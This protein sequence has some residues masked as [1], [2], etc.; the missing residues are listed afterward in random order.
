MPGARLIIN[1]RYFHIARAGEKADGKHSMTKEAAMGLVEYVGTREGVELNVP[2]QMSLYGK[3]G[4]P[5]NLDPLRLSP[6]VAARPA[7]QKQINTIIDLLEAI[8]EAKNTLEF[9]DY[10]EH[11]TIGNATELISH[12]SELGLGYA[13][14]YGKAANLVEYVG[15]RPGVV[16]VG[17][18]GLFSSSPNVDMKK[19]QEEI[20]N[21]KGNIWTHVISLRREDADM[22][23]YN[24]QKPWRDLVMQKIDVI[25]KASN[26]PVSQLHWYAGMHNTTHHPHIHLFVF[27][28]DP[29]VGHLT[30]D[31]INKMKSAFSEVIFADE[32]H[33][34][35]AHKDDMR[36]GIKKQ[37]DDILEG[38]SLDSM[39]HFSKVEQERICQKMTHLAADL[40]DKPG[41]KQY[42]WLLRDMDVRK[43]VDDIMS[44]LAKTPVIQKLYD[45]YCADH[46]ALERMYREDPKDITPIINNNE[47]RSVKN[48][49][50]QEAIKLSSTM[51]DSTE[52]EQIDPSSDI[53]DE[54]PS[55]PDECDFSRGKPNLNG[56]EFSDLFDDEQNFMSLIDSAPPEQEPMSFPSDHD[57]VDDNF[58]AKVNFEEESLSPLLESE[59][60]D[61]AGPENNT[62]VSSMSTDKFVTNRSQRIRNKPDLDS[63]W[64][65]ATEMND[66]AAQYRLGK[67]YL[68]GDQVEKD[69]KGAQMLLNKSVKGGNSKAA[70][71]LGKMFLNGVGVK[72]DYLKARSLLTYAADDGLR[73]AQYELGKMFFY[74]KG[75]QRDYQKARMFYGLAADS[76]HGMAKYELGKMYLY[77]IGIDKDEKLGKEYCLE[78]YYDFTDELQEATGM[79]LE[80]DHF[81]WAELP[82]VSGYCSYLEYLVGRMRLAG[83]GVDVNYQYAFDW[84]RAASLHGHVHS[85]YMLAKMICDGQGVPQNY[86]DA[87]G[88]FAEAAE[89]GDKYASY[90]VGRMYYRGVGVAQDFAK[91]ASF[92]TKAAEEN[93]PYAD[94]TLAQ[95]AETGQGME[96]S[97]ENA[98]LLYKKALI[99][100][101]E[102]EK[103]QPDPLT[104]FRIAKIYLTGKGTE[105]N[106]EEGAKWLEKA[107]GGGNAQA[108]YEL[109]MMCA[110]G[111]SI[112][113]DEKKAV[114]LFEKALAAFI[115]SDKDNPN[116]GQEYRIAQMFE[117]GLGTTVSY[118]EAIKWYSAAAENGHGHAAYRL[119][120]FY[121]DGISI[122]QDYNA[123]LKWFHR[124]AELEN[125]YAYFALG[126]AYF[127]GTGT[128]KDYSK[129]ATW[130]QK[131]SDDGFPFA[132]YRLAAMYRLGI[133]VDADTEKADKLYLTA[134]SGFRESEEANPD[135]QLEYRIGSMYLNGEGTAADPQEALCWFLKS[136][137]NGN[138]FAA[139]Q[140]AQKLDE[141][142]C[143]DKD[144][145]KATKLY[146]N[147]LTGFIALETD[148]QDAQLEYRIGSMY[149]NGKGTA[150]DSQ[151]ALNWFL[152][153]A[154]GGNAFAAYQAA[155]IFSEKKDANRDGD[156][157]QEE[158]LYADALAGFL[159]MEK[160][161]PDAQLEYRIGS[162]YLVGKGTAADPQKALNLFLK[163][164][165]G[166]NAF[167]AYQAAQMLDEGKQVDQDEAK[168]AKLYTDALAGFIAL[169]VDK[170]DAQLEYRI[171]SMLL[172]GEG[173]E[174]DVD[175][176]MRW[177]QMSAKSGNPYAEYQM[178]ELFEE[179]TKVPKADATGLYAE[180]LSS[181]L[182]LDQKNPDAM[183]EYR[184]G[185]MYLAGKGTK[186]D[187]KEAI[188]WFER[189][190]QKGNHYAEYQMAELYLDGT[191][192]TKDEIHAQDLF[193]NA[194]QGFLDQENG[195][196]DAQLEY[197][198]ASMYLNGHGTR[199]NVQESIRWFEQSMEKG[200]HY[201][202]Y[203]MAELYQEGIE[204]SK[205]EELAQH[206]FSHALQDFLDQEKDN[207]DAQL[208][209]RIASMYLNGHGARK[210][211]QEAIRWFELSAEKGNDYAKYQMAELYH[212]G[213]QIPK[214]EIRAQRLFAE[215]LNDF[216]QEEKVNPDAQREYR[217]GSM[218]LAGKG[219]AKNASEALHWFELSAQKGNYYAE[220]QI[221][222]LYDDGKDIPQNKARAQIYYNRALNGFLE[223]EQSSQDAAMEYRIGQ[224]F[225]MG[226]GTYKDY[227][228]AW[229]WFSL[230][231][232][233]DNTYALLQQA[234]MLQKG[235]GVPKSE[236]QA[237]ALYAEAFHK[238]M[239]ALQDS[240]SPKL[241]YRIGTMYEFGLGV[242]RDVSTAKAWYQQAA[243]EGDENASSRLK[244]IEEFEKEQAV[245]SV[246]R[247]FRLFA[248]TLGHNVQDSTTHKYHVDRK[249]VQKQHMLHKQSQNQE[250][251]M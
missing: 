181:F 175:E 186:R 213:T 177:F 201:A 204:I 87:A 126:K 133:G 76:G 250:Q 94:Y 157:T 105:I 139:Y 160:I 4:T 7:T 241:R 238:L 236:Q 44:D 150:Y 121:A 212:E 75:V 85:E 88:Y 249:L 123:A 227:Q 27:S 244:Q 191:K 28:D 189:S 113:K 21:C 202:E 73:A 174:K 11:Q 122:P 115:S 91:A 205:D 102:Q 182:L 233:K 130:F 39:N 156:G 83:E 48:K 46:I 165:D 228:A 99:E 72:K 195:N 61:P 234:R 107:V 69:L 34:I 239:K 98:S 23:G 140:A 16:R 185:S 33:Q 245:N 90:T 84:F 26:I 207:P 24:Q 55:I 118:S 183:A 235:E 180:A 117:K 190:A 12:A 159:S 144:E 206:L 101:M 168:A 3:D 138:A 210:S 151:K 14:D 63:L 93:V 209:Y 18:H 86:A 45:M 224:M 82:Q 196:P 155:Q 147:A 109:A 169:E 92:F 77:G 232:A 246:M 216:L 1:S 248:R 116:A 220:Y 10:K 154:G 54:D 104:E 15:K 134:L 231:A 8:P 37:V 111:E 208:E 166:G 221:A 145:T 178:A 30:V 215:A 143:V 19:A 95:M 173:I 60:P 66:S 158:K 229:H 184:I 187:P 129:S 226:Q 78:S 127:D 53:F 167:A 137:D 149:L 124:A 171:G 125:K 81:T 74:E 62:E 22:L 142:K 136:A 218:L 43:Q 197:S 5:L 57:S 119:G 170:P 148:K 13:V 179:G 50:I 40:K 96:K 17:E 146:A 103:Q 2:D 247:L 120:K 6:E 32:R 172:C 152:K 110:S 199:K 56:P 211:V 214:D 35:Y 242:K 217:I 163:S 135:I 108:E 243:Q 100:F 200:N 164:A 64:R 59:S 194:L 58:S 68:T 112:P 41:K 9:Q 176:A 29:K 51:P 52:K 38:L 65:K 47:F 219:K 188:H 49:I 230:S 222:E 25:A 70:L 251:G 131:A 128:V 162:M 31:G 36:N 153:S 132:S 80:H 20:A 223:A 67:M 97:A 161:N 79:N 114:K 225:Y 89:K 240:P 198:I 203:Q 42:G 71:E 106:P 141:G 193:T 192:V 237:Q